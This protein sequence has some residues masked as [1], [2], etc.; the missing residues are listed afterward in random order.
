MI[1]IDRLE[2]EGRLAGVGLV[3]LELR[4]GRERRPLERVAD[5]LEVAAL[6]DGGGDVAE[7]VDLDEER[8]RGLVLL[9]RRRRMMPRC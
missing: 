1:G 4:V 6:R 5:R 2:G 8:P 3:A 7:G 9:L